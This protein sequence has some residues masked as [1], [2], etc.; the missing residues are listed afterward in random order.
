MGP[1]AKALR[2]LRAVI[3]SVDL[4]RGQLRGR[5]LKF[6]R[7]RQLLRVKYPAPRLKGPAADADIDA[8]RFLRGAGFFGRLAHRSCPEKGRM[9]FLGQA[10]QIAPRWPVRCKDAPLAGS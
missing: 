7:L 5:V 9:Q 8:A 10:T 1:F 2:L 3:G 4:D 6:L